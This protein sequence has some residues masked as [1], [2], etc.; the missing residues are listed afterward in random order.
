MTLKEAAEGIVTK[1]KN[2]YIIGFCDND[3]TELDATGLADLEKVWAEFCED[4]KLAEDC[5]DF[6][7]V[8]RNQF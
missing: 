7:E 5:I 8:S 2:T 6:V 1:R 4:N 3:E